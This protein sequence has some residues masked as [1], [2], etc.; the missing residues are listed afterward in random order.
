M[1]ELTENVS[2]TKRKNLLE[3]IGVTSST[4]LKTPSETAA[5]SNQ[6]DNGSNGNSIL[7]KLSTHTDLHNIPSNDQRA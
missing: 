6:R 5:F 2:P 3:R 7:H 4:M 1:G